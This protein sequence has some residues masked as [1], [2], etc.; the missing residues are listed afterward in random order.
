MVLVVV[1]PL[2]IVVVVTRTMTSI[3]SMIAIVFTDVTTKPIDG[4]P[5][6]KKKRYIFEQF[7]RYASQQIMPGVPSKPKEQDCN[8]DH[9]KGSS[10]KWITLPSPQD[11][12]HIVAQTI[13]IEINSTNMDYIQVHREALQGATC[14]SHSEHVSRSVQGK[15]HQQPC[16]VHQRNR[17]GHEALT[18][19]SASR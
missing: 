18:Q 10:A 4:R 11:S 13:R 9:G 16:K 6:K 17:R 12:G 19:I 8:I 5:V 1:I 14:N 3:V 15:S 7:P 2:A